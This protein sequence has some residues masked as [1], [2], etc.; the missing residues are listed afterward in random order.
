MKAK[1]PEQRVNNLRGSQLGVVQKFNVVRTRKGAFPT[2]YANVNL[3]VKYT[4]F[5]ITLI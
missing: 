4:D 2:V 3:G 5:K 1:G